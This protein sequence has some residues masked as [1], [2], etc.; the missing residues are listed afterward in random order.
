MIW[1]AGEQTLIDQTF[2]LAVPEAQT[3]FLRMCKQISIKANKVKW[4]YQ[5]SGT[6]QLKIEMV[7]L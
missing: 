5:K 7:S 4:G 3:N 2:V 1:P 6:W